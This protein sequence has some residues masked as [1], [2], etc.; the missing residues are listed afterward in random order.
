MQKQ[1]RVGFLLLQLDEFAK[2]KTTIFMLLFLMGLLNN[3][4][5]VVIGTSAQDLAIKFGKSSWMPAFQM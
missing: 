2:S 3:N 5:Y 1:T 4:T